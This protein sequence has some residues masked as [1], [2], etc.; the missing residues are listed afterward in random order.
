MPRFRVK[1]GC[2]AE[3]IPGIPSWCHVEHTFSAQ[4]PKDAGNVVQII[5]TEEGLSVDE[6]KL[7]EVEEED[8]APRSSITFP[9]LHSAGVRGAVEVGRRQLYGL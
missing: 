5:A 2:W 9:R 4:S 3:V 7:E 6:C 8:T 1:Y